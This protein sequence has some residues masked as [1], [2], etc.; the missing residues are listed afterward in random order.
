MTAELP[1]VSISD[2]APAY[3]PLAWVGM[4]GIDLPVPVREPGCHRDLHARI[5]A[6]VDLPRPEIKGIHMSRLY[7]LLDTLSEGEGLTPAGL[8]LLLARMIESHADCG[9]GNAR[10]RVAFD[11]LVRRP[12][13][14]TESLSGWTSYPV[15]IDASVI[16]GGYRCRVEVRVGYSSTCPCSAALSRQVVEQGFRDAFAGKT[17]VTP[18]DVANW[19]RGNASAAT[20]HSQRSEAQVSVEADPAANCFGLLAL[21][22]RIEA[23]LRTPVQTA[24]KRADEQAFAVLNG[25]NLMFVED[26]ARR[27]E[28]ALDGYQ[29]PSVHVRHFES[30]HPHDAVAW[31]HTGG[32]GR[33]QKAPEDGS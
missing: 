14:V 29:R 16:N 9:S 31:T 21:I 23:T 3:S 1:D 24:V 26:A 17:A 28:A 12:A 4:Q 8:R 18:D 7:R 19:L 22:D 27:I 6:Q 15:Q 10:L 32:D 20:P 11:L 5:D 30:L 2:A 33:S 13:L 25:R